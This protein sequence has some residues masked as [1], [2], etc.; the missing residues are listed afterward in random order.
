MIGIYVVNNGLWTII[1]A[2]APPNLNMQVPVKVSM[3]LQYNIILSSQYIKLIYA[4]LLFTINPGDGIRTIYFTLY[5]LSLRGNWTWGGIIIGGLL[6]F[7]PFMLDIYGRIV[8]VWTNT[9]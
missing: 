8:R 2:V 3:P 4:A 7:P 9:Y 1:G 5:G 6:R